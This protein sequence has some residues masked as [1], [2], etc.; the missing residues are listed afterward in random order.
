MFKYLPGLRTMWTEAASEVAAGE[1]DD[2]SADE[3]E[4]EIKTIWGQSTPLQKS[5]LRRYYHEYL[6]RKKHSRFIV[7]DTNN[8]VVNLHTGT[9]SALE[10][11][12]RA[13][14]YLDVAKAALEIN[15]RDQMLENE[16]RSDPE[17]DRMIVVHSD[18]NDSDEVATVT[19][20]T[21][22]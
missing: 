14:R 19:A 18:R 21:P 1:L 16:D 17:V 2:G 20:V 5:V 3:D 12:K 13:H 15:R 4:S 9:G 8:V 22:D 10:P 7:V 11:F 6:L